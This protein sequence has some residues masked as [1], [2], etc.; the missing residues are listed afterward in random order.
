[1]NSV[2]QCQCHN[3]FVNWSPNSNKITYSKKKLK[4]KKGQNIISQKSLGYY[5]YKSQDEYLLRTIFLNK[6]M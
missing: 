5:S 1:M 6:S 3:M 2:P 4:I